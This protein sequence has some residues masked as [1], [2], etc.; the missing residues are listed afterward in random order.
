MTYLYT[1]NDDLARHRN[2]WQHTAEKSKDPDQH[3]IAQAHVH[4]RHNKTL[5]GMRT[6]PSYFDSLTSHRSH[7][8]HQPQTTTRCVRQNDGSSQRMSLNYASLGLL[9]RINTGLTT[10]VPAAVAQAL[11]HLPS[12]FS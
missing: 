10:R 12:K 5:S 9:S 2:G 3:E 1:D 4:L 11:N 6:T 7:V 8:T